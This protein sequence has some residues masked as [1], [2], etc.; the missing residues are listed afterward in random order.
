MTHH[1]E[2]DG[3]PLDALRCASCGAWIVQTDTSTWGDWDAPSLVFCPGSTD[4]DETDTRHA[5]D[6]DELRERDRDEDP[7]PHTPPERFTQSERDDLRDAGR[8]HLLP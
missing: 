5:P 6:P 3:P 7:R 8:G 1:H 2:H 4:D